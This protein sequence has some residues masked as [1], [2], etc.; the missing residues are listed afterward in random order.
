LETKKWGLSFISNLQRREEGTFCASGLAGIE[1][2]PARPNGA[3]YACLN[4]SATAGIQKLTGAKFAAAGA[5]AAAAGA[6]IN[7]TQ[8]PPEE[9]VILGDNN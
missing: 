1:P 8:E 7:G 4:L 9:R 2:T 5:A 6:S 3:G